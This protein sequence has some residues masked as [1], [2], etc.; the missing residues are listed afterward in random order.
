M[1][2]KEDV[3]T[4]GIDLGGTKIA[5]APLKGSQLIHDD[6]I[7]ESTPQT[8]AED[9]LATME[10][11][12]SKI[13]EKHDIQ[14]IGISTAGMVDDNGQMI[15]SCG[16][17]R[18]WK[19]TK[20]KKELEAKTGIFTYVENDANCA[21][22]GEYI[23]GSGKN[24][25]SIVMVTLG[26]GIGGGIVFD[27]QIWRGAHFGGGE[28]GHMKIHSA[29]TRRCTCG[30]WDCW[31]AYASGT[32]LNN[33][34]RTHLA[35]PTIDNYKLIDMYKSGDMEAIAVIGVWH[36]HIAQGVS[37]LINAFD[38]AAVIVGGGLAQFVDY[39]KL[40]KKIKDRVVDGLKPHVN[41]LKGILDNDSGMI[42]A[43]CLAN[44]NLAA[45]QVG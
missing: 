41:V 14:G 40:N 34:A 5:A 36:D 21:A 35:D 1:S 11:M 37:S 38:P 16:N 23:A 19:G 39:A 42:G 4:I 12:I 13:R 15:G 28:I 27:N 45:V 24:H 44:L 7:K 3:I 22:F 8:G 31:E 20:V 2:I 17:L 29:K 9:I 10:A 6:L 43:A 30:S 18:Y 25:R 33:T 26:T 32:G